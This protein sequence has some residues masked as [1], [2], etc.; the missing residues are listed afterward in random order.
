MNA[1]GLCPSCRE[2]QDAAPRATTC[3]RCGRAW[4]EERTSSSTQALISAFEQSSAGE[5]ESLRSALTDAAPALELVDNNTGHKTELL[6]R[7]LISQSAGRFR[8]ETHPIDFGFAVLPAALRV[9]VSG[10]G[11]GFLDGAETRS[12]PKAADTLAEWSLFIVDGLADRWGQQASDR[13]WF[14]IDRAAV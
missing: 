7:E 9:E 12:R 14:E 3:P 4:E 5:S 13:A 11:L 6:I 10:T 8:S 2:P 1:N